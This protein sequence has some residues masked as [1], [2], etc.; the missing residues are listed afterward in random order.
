MGPVTTNPRPG[1]S[2]ARQVWLP[3]AGQRCW[4]FA[5]GVLAPPDDGPARGDGY[6]P[7]LLHGAGVAAGVGAGWGRVWLALAAY[8]AGFYL[9]DVVEVTAR[10]GMT[11]RDAARLW[12]LVEGTDAQAVFVLG[13]D[14]IEYTV[15][16]PMATELRVVIRPVPADHHLDH[17]TDR[18]RDDRK[19]D[20]RTRGGG[21]GGTDH[22]VGGDGT[23]GAAPGVRAAGP[24]RADVDVT[25][26]ADL[27]VDG[28]GHRG[29]PLAPGTT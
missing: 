2:P 19:T 13:L 8:R 14:E 7:D 27:G 3:G 5:V 24:V 26:G 11:A 10:T 1:W 4:P 15:L 23:G 29:E 18:G 6:D 9:L 20:G 25:D 21:D 28:G 16:E 22:A 17:P 12:T